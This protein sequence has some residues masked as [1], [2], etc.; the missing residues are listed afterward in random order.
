LFAGGGFVF[1]T[2]LALPGPPGWIPIVT[3]IS[4][5]TAVVILLLAASILVVRDHDVPD[6]FVSFAAFAFG[7]SVNL[8]VMI[9]AGADAVTLIATVVAIA[10]VPV[11]AVSYRRFGIAGWFLVGASLPAVL[12]WGFF[13]VQDLMTPSFTYAGDLLVWFASAAGMTALG[14]FSVAIGDR[15]PDQP[16]LRPP[17][18]PDPSRVAAVATAYLGARRAGTLDVPNA[19]S[20][21]LAAAAWIGTTSILLVIGADVALATLV[22]MALFVALGTELFYRLEPRRLRVAMA[23]HAFVGSPEM[24]R[25]RRELGGPIPYSAATAAEWLRRNPE[26]DAN[27]WARPELLAWTGAI[28][29]ADEV[30]GRMPES[31]QPE[32][33]ER[34]SLQVLV[35]LVAGRPADIAGLEAFA[36]DVGD[37]GSDDRLRAVA[38]A[39]L[40]RS[41]ERLIHGGDWIGPLIDAQPRIGPGALGIFRSDTWLSRVRGLAVVGAIIGLAA[42]TQAIF[43]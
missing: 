14:L 35:D 1:F 17:S 9:L 24:R 29:E 41:R 21:G 5:A 18:E 27:R 6:W 2:V 7:I 25:F 33:F 37:P 39:A 11:V 28:D 12:W 22:G 31:T 40:T 15:L 4:G 16:P 34:R 42:V 10:V 32:R 13:I 3:T 38:I 23:T 26:T 30:I 20:L 8:S 36:E 43:L 19:L